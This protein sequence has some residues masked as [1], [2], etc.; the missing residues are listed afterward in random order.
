MPQEVLT[1]LESHSMAKNN[2]VRGGRYLNA[3]PQVW[4]PGGASGKVPVQ[5]TEE[6]QV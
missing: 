4:F 1:Y 3:P 5:E 2:S 6:M